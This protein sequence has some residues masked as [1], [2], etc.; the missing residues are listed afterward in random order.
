MFNKYIL[1]EYMCK[2]IYATCSGTA[3][4]WTQQ[5]YTSQM[6]K[7]NQFAVGTSSISGSILM[8]DTLDYP[9]KHQRL[10]GLLDN[11]AADS[12][13]TSLYISS[14]YDGHYIPRGPC[15]QIKKKNT[16]VKRFSTWDSKKRQ[17]F[18]SCQNNSE[19]WMSFAI[20]RLYI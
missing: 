8:D 10:L 9:S 14:L 12:P 19:G 17:V 20:F 13:Q 2:N 7:E 6:Q 16:Q 5:Q 4:N 3:I 15:T 18:V 1:I 11:L